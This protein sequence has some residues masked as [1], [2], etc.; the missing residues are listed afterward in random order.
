MEEKPIVIKEVIRS[1]CNSQKDD[2]SSEIT[3]KGSPYSVKKRFGGP[4]RMLEE[5]RNGK[6]T[7]LKVNLKNDL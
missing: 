6:F 4:T 1:K 5:G 3:A 7:C 2:F